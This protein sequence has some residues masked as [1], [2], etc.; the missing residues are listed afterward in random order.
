MIKEAE[1]E[2]KERRGRDQMQ[3]WGGHRRV[4][5]F[6]L[7]L[8]ADYMLNITYGKM[9]EEPVSFF[10][11]ENVPFL[12]FIKKEQNLHRCPLYLSQSRDGLIRV[13]K[14]PLIKTNTIQLRWAGD[15][16]MFIKRQVNIVR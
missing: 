13:L 10:S 3:Y 7:I 15:S 1:N 5:W 11:K 4:H 9:S 6:H 14:Q 12:I 2:S 16:R 8:S